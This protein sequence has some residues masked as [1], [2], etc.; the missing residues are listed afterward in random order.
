MSEH[1]LTWLI[2]LPVLAALAAVFI[3]RQRH[4]W[5]RV[6]NL[7][8]CAAQLLLLIVAIQ[9]YTTET[10]AFRLVEKT[11]WFSLNLGSWGNLQAEYF[12][13]V[14]GLSFP[15][16]G[17]SVFIMLVAAISSWTITKSVKGYFIL[18]LV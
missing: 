1:I 8:V 16:I 7:V 11:K 4:P 12:L 9:K 6:L 10:G 15:L 3:P 17:L 18:M 14:D 13:A 2:F 5:F